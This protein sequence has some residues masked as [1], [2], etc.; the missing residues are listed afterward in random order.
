MAVMGVIIILS[1][2]ALVSLSILIYYTKEHPEE[3]H[4]WKTRIAPAISFIA[5][6]IVIFLLFKNLL[7]LGS[8]YHYAVWLGPIDLLVV[9]IGVGAAFYFKH[10]NRE[11][12]ES[13]GRLVNEGL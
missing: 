5:Q 13:A 3:V 7:F 6:V 11:K 8:G 4:W 12:Y 10:R 2:Q 1:V 9:L